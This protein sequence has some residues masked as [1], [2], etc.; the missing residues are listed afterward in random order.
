MLM[1]EGC[2]QG[3]YFNFPG[4][5]R[6]VFTKPLIFIEEAAKRIEEFCARRKKAEKQ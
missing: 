5:F 1:Q 3:D 2:F 6:V 4:Y